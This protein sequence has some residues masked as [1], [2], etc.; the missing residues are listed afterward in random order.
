MCALQQHNI[1]FFIWNWAD[2][3]GGPAEGNPWSAARPNVILN[4]EYQIMDVI[5]TVNHATR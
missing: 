4:I 3:A 1:P 5:D 2:P